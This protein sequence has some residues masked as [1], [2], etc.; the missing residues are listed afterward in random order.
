MAERQLLEHLAQGLAL[1]DIATSLDVT[2]HTV[3]A[4]LNALMRKS[5]QRSQSGLVVLLERLRVMEV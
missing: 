1:A 5:G 4:P 3:R 2:I